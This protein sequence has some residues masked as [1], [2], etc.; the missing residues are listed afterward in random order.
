MCLYLKGSQ[1]KSILEV[2]TILSRTNMT[3]EKIMAMK[4]NRA[5]IERQLKLTRKINELISLGY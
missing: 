1:F 2:E 4:D 3:T 5:E